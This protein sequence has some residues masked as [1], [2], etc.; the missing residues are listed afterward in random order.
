MAE[1]YNSI[2][3]HALK[4]A[5]ELMCVAARTAPKARGRDNLVITI[6]EKK[7][8]KQVIKKMLEIAERDFLPSCAR[9]AGNI[10]NTDYMVVIGTKKRTVGLNCGYCGNKTCKELEKTN[11]VCAIS[12]ICVERPR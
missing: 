1:E 12:C 10:Q 2:Q 9:D 5:A 8:K 11:G 6:L 7:E 4:N 3:E